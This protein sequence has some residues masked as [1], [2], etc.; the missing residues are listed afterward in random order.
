MDE[1]LSLYG[2]RRLKCADKLITTFR[3]QYS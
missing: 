1:D 3:L 2:R